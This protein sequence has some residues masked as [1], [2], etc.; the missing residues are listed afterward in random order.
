MDAK[1]SIDYAMICFNGMT[2]IWWCVFYTPAA[3]YM[4]DV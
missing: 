4:Y 3:M 1:K 2:Q